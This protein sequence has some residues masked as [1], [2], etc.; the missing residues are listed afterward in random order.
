MCSILAKTNFSFLRIFLGS[1]CTRAAKLDTWPSCQ[2][3]HLDVLGRPRRY[4][5]LLDIFI[6]YIKGVVW[7]HEKLHNGFFM[8]KNKRKNTMRWESHVLIWKYWH[9]NSR[10]ML[11]D[12][13]QSY[14]CTVHCTLQRFITLRSALAVMG[15]VKTHHLVCRDQAQLH[16]SSS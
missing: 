2:A 3:A 12:I 15:N 13:F 11:W 7:V 5:G 8:N 16:I 4:T 14:V 6:T 9:S 10:S 1:I